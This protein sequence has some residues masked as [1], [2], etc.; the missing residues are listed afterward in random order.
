MNDSVLF[1][2]FAKG[3]SAQVKWGN[4]CGVYTR[5]STKE[6]ADKNR[7]W[8][9]NEN[10]VS[11]SLLKVGIRFRVILAALMNAPK[12]MSERSLTVCFHL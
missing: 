7:A 3:K 1:E 11:N 12:Q 9:R 6:Q 8:K 5:V 10:T 4:N 2:N